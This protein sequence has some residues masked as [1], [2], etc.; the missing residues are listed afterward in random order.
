MDDLDKLLSKRM[1]PKPRPNLAD[2]IVARTMQGDLR[3]GVGLFNA[4]SD[5]MRQNFLLPQ[6]G[7]A[8]ATVLVLGIWLGA[9]VEL[10]DVFSAYTTDDVEDAIIIDIQTEDWL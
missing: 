5:F 3:T 8:L 7:V 9:N 4:L 2:D 10:D 1:T 6:P